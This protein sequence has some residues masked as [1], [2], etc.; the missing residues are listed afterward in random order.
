MLAPKMTGKAA[1]RVM[2]PALRNP[3]RITDVALELWITAVTKTPTS[4]DFTLLD[5]TFS[6]RSLRKP[7]D[8]DLRALLRT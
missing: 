7:K 1:V 2:I 6:R 8:S 4:A 5:V 3:M